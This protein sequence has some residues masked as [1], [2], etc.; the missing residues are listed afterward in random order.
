MPF[1]LYNLTT[2]KNK[3]PIK[4]LAVKINPELYFALKE[5]SITEGTKI[6][7]LLNKAVKNYLIAKKIYKE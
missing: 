2:M 7:F 3:A 6:K 1:L 4:E 5:L